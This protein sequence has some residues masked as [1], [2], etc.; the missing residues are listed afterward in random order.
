MV[1]KTNSG[2]TLSSLYKASAC[3]QSLHLPAHH[4]SPPSPTSFNPFS[5]L[6]HLPIHPSTH[7]NSIDPSFLLFSNFPQRT[8]LLS[9]PHCL[10]A[11]L[12][13]SATLLHIHP[14]PH[15]H[16]W[17]LPSITTAVDCWL[18]W[19]GGGL[20]AVLKGTLSPVAVDKG[21]SFTHSFHLPAFCLSGPGI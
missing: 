6:I 12:F 19:S 21:I 1:N 18:H 2:R 7:A 9:S 16:T 3:N 14:A 4:S 15:S 20:R 8:F 17:E 5:L 13:W 10:C 11:A